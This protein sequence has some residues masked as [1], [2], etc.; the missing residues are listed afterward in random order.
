[1]TRLD[2][3]ALLGI[4]LA[5]GVSAW[6]AQAVDATAPANSYGNVG[7]VQ[8]PTARFA[9]AG[10]F[11]V[12][13][14]SARPYDS[15]FI[16]AHPYDWLEATFRYTKFRYS[17]ID[18]DFVRDGYLDKSFDFKLRLSEESWTW[19]S[20]A[21]GVQDLGGTGLLSSEFLVATKRAGAFEMTLGL[22]WGRQGTR[23]DLDAPLSGISDR[24][25]RRQN[26]SD[27]GVGDFELDRLFAG[28]AAFFGG[29]RWSPAGS[30]WSVMV[31]RE[32]NDY[33]LE[34]YG[35]NLDVKWPVN[36]GVAYEGSW[37]GAR[38]G[39]ERG[40]QFT[41]GFH[42]AVD[43]SDAGPAKALDAPP[44]PVAPP[45]AP[46]TYAPSDGGEV[47][48][49]AAR[50]R[51][52]AAALER[53]GINLIKVA[54][55]DEAD[56]MTAWVG[57]SPYRKSAQVNGR[58]ARVLAVFAP[59][60]VVRVEV[61]QVNRGLEQTRVTFIRS[62]LQ[63]AAGGQETPAFPLKWAEFDLPALE[64]V[65]EDESVHRH[66]SDFE[67]SLRPRY[68]QSFGDPDDSYRAGLFVALGLQKFW[69]P[70]LSSS[71]VAEASL[72]SNLDD[73]ERQSDSRL[74]R[75]RSDIARYQSEGEDGLREFEANYIRP[76][77]PEWF[78]R[79]S[80]GIFEEMYGGVAVETLFR[81]Y[82]QNW[83]VGVNM[84]RVRQRDFDQQFSFR[85]YEVTTGHLTFYH[86]FYPLSIES[87]LSVGR[88]L[89]GDVGGTISMARVFDS[90]A[91]I[92]V[93]ATKTD[94]SSEEFGE[95]SFDKGFFFSMPFDLF[96]PKSTRSSIGLNFRP[97]TR[98]GG[99]KVSDGW[100]LFDATSDRDFLEI[101]RTR[102]AMMD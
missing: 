98:D 72:I 10:T 20:I 15:S 47:S 7:L 22:G 83:A 43:L 73:I 55:T 86:R 26:N 27:P 16:T 80:A 28:D 32:G 45:S 58:V 12:G 96:L 24:F 65:P 6:P 51:D 63:L 3:L 39:W 38:A 52:I 92:G 79:A 70:Y 53:Q 62:H 57:Q 19:P 14:S 41:L 25:E 5:L 99:Q 42:V 13:F 56:V 68:R 8:T 49:D 1:M 29:V 88:Y 23:S 84:N 100:R 35:N 40:E 50:V 82:A 85:D 48:T 54:A 94:V 59:E 31:E 4:A 36:L 9:P 74:P 61:V 21:V 77:T 69:T 18:G 93:F 97:L 95:G 90:G 44:T 17:G 64:P 75:V 91:R 33:Q 60:T 67:W 78:V 46:P 2:R 66:W 101:V 102:G 37:F 81:P 71:L 11:R 87:E 30:P 89:A 34:P 76:L